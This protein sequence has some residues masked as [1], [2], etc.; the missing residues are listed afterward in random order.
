MDRISLSFSEFKGFGSSCPIKILH[1]IKWPFW[2][3]FCVKNFASLPL[4]LHTFDLYDTYRK[5]SGAVLVSSEIIFST[6]L[7]LVSRQHC[8][9]HGKLWFMVPLAPL[10]LDSSVARVTSTALNFTQNLH[11]CDNGVFHN[12]KMVTVQLPIIINTY[13]NT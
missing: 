6:V 11:F 13:L 3:N 9:A 2:R 4:V 7:M 10:H 12:S 8:T 1:G 5:Y